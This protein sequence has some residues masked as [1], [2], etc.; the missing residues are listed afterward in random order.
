MQRRA[1]VLTSLLLEEEAA[2]AEMRSQMKDNMRFKAEWNQ[3]DTINGRELQLD[4]DW[5][6]MGLR[7][8]EQSSESKAGRGSL[9]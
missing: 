5:R 9:S 4:I 6:R 8:R 7:A 3:S 1:Q 2:A